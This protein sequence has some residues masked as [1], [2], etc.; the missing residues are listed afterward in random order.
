MA[1]LATVELGIPRHIGVVG[2]VS[3]CR[4][5]RTE[6]RC[7]GSRRNPH[8]LHLEPGYSD[9]LISRFSEL[10]TAK[11]AG[12]T[13]PLGTRLNIGHI[14]LPALTVGNWPDWLVWRLRARV[15]QVINRCH[16]R[17]AI[18]H[19]RAITRSFWGELVIGIL[20]GNRSG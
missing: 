19:D 1:L 13:K 10:K 14:R 9:Q 2:A 20:M 3:S 4:F 15:G 8:N 6:N 11:K 18:F 5:Q 16:Q 17:R 7:R 12:K